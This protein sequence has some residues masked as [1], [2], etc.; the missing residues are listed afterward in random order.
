M[1]YLAIGVIIIMWVIG[2][3]WSFQWDQKTQEPQESSAI[4]TKNSENSET[5]KK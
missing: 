5:P 3:Y 2:V 1:K 4:S